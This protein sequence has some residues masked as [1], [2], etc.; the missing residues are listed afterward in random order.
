MTETYQQKMTTNARI[1]S[2]VLTRKRSTFYALRE[3][4]DNSINADAKHIKIDFIPTDGAT[5][6]LQYHPIE[7]IIIEDDGIGVPF[8]EFGKC[9]MEVATDRRQEGYGVGRFSALQIGKVMKIMTTGFDK[10][11][12]KYTTTEVTFNVN[13]FRGQLE[14]KQFDVKSTVSDIKLDTGFKVEISKLYSNEGKC[15]LKNRLTS[16]F[17]EEIFPLSLFEVYHQHIFKDSI[18]FIHNGITLTKEQ[19]IKGVPHTFNKI[20]KDLRGENHGVRFMIYALKVQVEKGVRIFLENNASQIPLARFKYNSVWIA[21]EQESQFVIVSSDYINADLK[22]R[23]DMSLGD[24]KEWKSFSDFLKMEIEAYYKQSNVKYN[25]FIDAL[26]RDKSYP[27]S[28][29]EIKENGL[30]VQLFNNSL[31]MLNNDQDILNMKDKSR[32][33]FYN[34]FRKSLDD[35][36]V[37]YLIKHVLALT[38]ES[39][40]KMMQLIDDVNLDEVIRFT[41]T[42]AER[43]KVIE[44]L[45]EATIAN[46]EKNADA[47]IDGSLKSAIDKNFWIFGEEYNGLKTAP[48]D[49]DLEKAIKNEIKNRLAYKPKS[50]DGNLIEGLKQKVKKLNDLFFIKER[51]LNDNNREII[52]VFIKSPSTLINTKEAVALQ[53]FLMDIK[54]GQLFPNQNYHYVVMYIGTR[55]ESVTR[56]LIYEESDNSNN[57][58]VKNTS[59]GLTDLKAFAYEWTD[60]IQQNK[61]KM[62]FLHDSIKLND[63][64][65]LSSFIQE[66]GESYQPSSHGRL[67]AEK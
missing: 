45:Y 64:D 56:T 42:L 61:R 40:E 13:D 31:F 5:T 7:R 20:Y 46:V 4:I 34:M 58:V 55:I 2:K 32:T 12:N 3:L 6:D 26:K 8:N 43:K 27:F 30:Q 1:V 51:L 52:I 57:H 50:N 60:L 41:S 54:E 19:F 22:D 14:D 24:D 28:E 11:L 44:N 29:D 37:G 36:N 9:I 65:T 33:T 16:N 21:P 35:G 18:A 63:L 38:K 67:T 39:R 62:E 17:K 10:S 53:R 59:N 15:D 66:Y 25:S 23:Y 49:N 48:L 47:W